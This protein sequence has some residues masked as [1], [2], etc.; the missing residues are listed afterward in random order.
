MGLIGEGKDERSHTDLEAMLVL[1]CLGSRDWF[2]KLFPD[3]KAKRLMV[4]L[5]FRQTALV[6]THRRTRHSSQIHFH[7]SLSFYSLRL[8]FGCPHTSDSH[9]FVFFWSEVS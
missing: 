3:D 5:H 2:P 8:I 4:L 1:Q 9:V 7:V 6:K